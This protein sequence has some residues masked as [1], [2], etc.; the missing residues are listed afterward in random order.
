MISIVIITIFSFLLEGIVSNIVSI[1]SSLFVPL[2]SI[3]SLILIYPFFNNDNSNFLKISF[4]IGLFYDFVY[5]DTLILNAFIFLTI[6]YLIKQIN[7]RITNNVFNVIFMSILVI[8]TYR[9][10]TYSVLVFTNYLSWNFEYLL[11]SIYSS[12]ILNIIFVVIVYLI[13]DY[14]SRKYRIQKID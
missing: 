9:I 8:S 1:N 7:K 5:T 6:G 11:K 13:A 4:I 2:F 3:I 10:V 14:F 12:L